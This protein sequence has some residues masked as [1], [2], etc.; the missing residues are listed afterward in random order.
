[1]SSLVS[2][3]S[4]S[5]TNWQA[6]LAAAL[7]GVAVAMNIGKVPITMSQLRA[8]FHLSLVMAGWISS[9]VNTMAVTTALLF[10][11]L[12]DRIGALRMCFIGLGIS[13]LGGALALFADSGT[14]LFVSRFA[15]GA[16]MVSVAV[17][18]PALLSAASAPSDQHKTQNNKKTKQP[19]GAA[20]GSRPKPNSYSACS[21]YS[22]PD[23][24]IAFP[25]AP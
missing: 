7:C 2:P 3:S 11:L 22:I 6:V 5:S 24:P 13:V 17:S 21:R 1:M 8:D 19:V 23:A 16:G 25:H 14:T 9:M 15:E 4:S 18:A 20:S 12:G 10:G